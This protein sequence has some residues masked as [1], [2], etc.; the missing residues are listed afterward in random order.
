MNR[1]RDKKAILMVSFGTSHLDT[2]E[3]NIAVIERQA[4]ETFPDYTV[5][6]A[7]TS[8]MILRKLQ[9]TQNLHICTVR[10]AMEQ[11]RTEQVTEVLV[12]PTHIIP[13]LEYEKM[14]AD[15]KAYGED[16]RRITVGE[17]LLMSG[18]DYKR[19]VRAVMEEI[20]LSEGEALVLM[21]HGTEHP[22]NAAYPV[23]EY[24][25]HYLGYAQVLVGTVEGSPDLAEVMKKLQTAGVRKVT[26]LPFMVVAGDHAKNDM[27][28]EEDS[29]K[30]ILL[31]A[32]YEVKTIVKGLG[33]LA[34]IRALYMEHMQAAKER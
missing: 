16:F 9:R 29:W 17:P 32:G 18:E 30:A 6:R 12:Q 14:L 27:A 11:M 24:M 8:G 15:V 13:G 2:L 10:E 7:F 5:Y 34:G 25:F 33:E 3:K 23:L 20:T 28:G 26:L 19:C 4:A 21:G 1:S 31:E 22:A